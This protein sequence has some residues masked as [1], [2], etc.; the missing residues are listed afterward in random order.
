MILTVHYSNQFKKDLKK[1]A[2]QRKNISQLKSL[3]NQLQN[4]M[5]LETKY[6]DHALKGNYSKHRECHIEPDWLL[7]YR[8]IKNELILVRTGS[9]SELFK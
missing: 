7:V 4:N 8:I 6:K 9:H 3:V 5:Q 2:K 1:A